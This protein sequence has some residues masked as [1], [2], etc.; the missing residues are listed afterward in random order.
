[1]GKAQLS[2]LKSLTRWI[3]WGAWHENPELGRTACHPIADRVD[4]LLTAES[5]VRH[6]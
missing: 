4:Q 1:M 5:V 3:V 2:A 6:H